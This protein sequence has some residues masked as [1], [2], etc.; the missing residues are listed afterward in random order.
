MSDKRQE[1]SKTF[2]QIGRCPSVHQTMP[3]GLLLMFYESNCHRWEATCFCRSTYCIYI[4]IS[5]LKTKNI[6]TKLYISFEQLRIYIFPLSSWEF[7][8][9]FWAAENLYISFEQLRIYIFP[10]S[11]WEFIYFFWAAENLYI[12]FEQMRMINM[13][14][15]SAIDFFEVLKKCDFF[16]HHCQNQFFLL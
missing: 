7:I 9:F 8:Y 4:D 13:L 1:L 15:T 11:S 2:K 3:S 10:L 14:P 6:N 16:L 12:S 5:L